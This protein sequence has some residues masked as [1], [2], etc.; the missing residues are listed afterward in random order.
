MFN[1]KTTAQEV[2]LDNNVSLTLWPRFREGP[3]IGVM[4]RRQL[5]FGHIVYFDHA[6]WAFQHP[7]M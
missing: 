3:H 7:G 2:N 4:F 6:S 1:Y 5:T